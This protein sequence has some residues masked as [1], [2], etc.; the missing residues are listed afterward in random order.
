M[1]RPELLE[2]TG[3]VTDG[4]GGTRLEAAMRPDIAEGLAKLFSIQLFS[5]DGAMRLRMDDTD[6]PD[7]ANKR[8]TK[9]ERQQRAKPNERHAARSFL[10]GPLLPAP[11]TA[12]TAAEN[13]STRLS[14]QNRKSLSERSP[15]R[16]TVATP[17]ATRSSG[18]TAPRRPAFLPPVN[19][20]KTAGQSKAI[21]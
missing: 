16:S 18:Q 9:T 5:P 21:A 13:T 14:I 20:P 19:Q 15:D 7:P 2:I 8:W 3:I 4:K 12:H 6:D 17:T 11:Q 10:A 1:S